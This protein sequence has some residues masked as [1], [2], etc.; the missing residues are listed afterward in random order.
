M[1]SGLSIIYSVF[2]THFSWRCNTPLIYGLKE[3]NQFWS[4]FWKDSEDLCPAIPTLLSDSKR[5]FDKK[6]NGDYFQK[7]Q[8]GGW[9]DKEQGGEGRGPVP[10]KMSRRQLPESTA[11]GN[12]LYS[13]WF[14]N[15]LILYTPIYISLHWPT[16]KLASG[17]LFLMLLVLAAPLTTSSRGHK[18]VQASSAGAVECRKTYFLFLCRTKNNFWCWS[19]KSDWS[20]AS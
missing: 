12:I 8:G 5:N 19:G 17:I 11:A 3:K 14:S 2:W 1:D 4:I 10:F 6:Q 15:V 16:Y 7:K 20:F 9:F 18:R 13:I